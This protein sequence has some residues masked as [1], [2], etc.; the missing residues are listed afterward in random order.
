MTVSDY[1]IKTISDSKYK[2]KHL[3]LIVGGAAMYLNDAVFRQKKIKYICGHHEQALTMAAEC[4]SRITG[5]LGVVMVTSGAAATNVLTGLLGAWWDS[6]PVLVISGNAKAD[7]LTYKTP[8]L[9]QLG[10]QDTRIVDIV[11]PITKYAVCIDD[12]NY[13]AY[14]TEKAI[15]FATSGRPGPVWLDVPLDVQGAEVDEKKL[16]KF[17]WPEEK[18]P[19]LRKVVKDTIQKIRTSKKPIILAGSGIRLSGSYDL[20]QQV[21]NKLKIPVLTSLTA[22]DLM[23]ETNPYYGGRFGPYGT[24]KGN[25][26]VNESDMMLILGERLYLWS[27]GYDYE[28][29]GKKAY[30]VMVEIDKEELNK[31]TLKI[32]Y[33]VL[34]DVKYFLEEMYKQL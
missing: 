11:K 17:T 23:W 16:V 4:Y 29:F 15:Y 32:D 13:V 19:D 18:K 2:V 9:R 5:G 3:F 28:N 21:V 31:K 7:M 6:I 24:F 27:I 26:L 22:H 14:H 34:G 20:F 8:N 10:V 30:K 25:D 1:I 33:P 12:P